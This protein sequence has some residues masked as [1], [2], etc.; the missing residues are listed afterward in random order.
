MK[1]LLALMCSLLVSASAYAQ[2]AT[3]T[4]TP[5]ETEAAPD[6]PAKAPV[7]PAVRIPPP[8][9]TD[10][11]SADKKAEA[12]KKSEADKKKEEP[13]I[14]GVVVSRGERGFLGVEIVNG[15]FKISFYDAKKKPIAPDVVRAALRWDAK[16]KVGQERLILNPDA[17]GKALAAP[18]VIRP[19][20][21]FKLY[22]TLIKEPTETENPV[23]ESHVIDFKA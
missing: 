5:G 3:A 21:N 19:P 16:Y 7:K 22:I 20:Y 17:E 23:G 2:A 11:K 4:A 1:P 13:I 12:A 14:K 6:A 15:T 18:K 8:A 9:K 10:A